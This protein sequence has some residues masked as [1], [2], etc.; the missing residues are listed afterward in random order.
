MAPAPPA[1]SYCGYA[2]RGTESAGSMTIIIGLLHGMGAQS[3]H[4]TEHLWS[5][6][7]NTSRPHVHATLVPAP[8][9][10]PLHHSSLPFSSPF[11]GSRGPPPC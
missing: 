7:P 5:S 8:S 3:I 10:P 11:G 1:A 6:L 4:L 2:D 9:L